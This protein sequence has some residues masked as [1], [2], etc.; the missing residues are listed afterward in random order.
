MIMPARVVFLMVTLVVTSLL[1]HWMLPSGS[2][3]L[4]AM[5]GDSLRVRIE[6]KPASITP[7]DTATVTVT[8]TGGGGAVQNASV[9]LRSSSGTF[10]DGSQLITG[11]TNRNGVIATKFF[12]GYQCVPIYSITV[13]ATRPG[14]VAG[15]ATAQIRGSR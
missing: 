14:M 5:Q 13:E 6:A 8:V 2:R 10:I 7:R 12:C 4:L 15:R 1:A 3:H 9:S 11:V